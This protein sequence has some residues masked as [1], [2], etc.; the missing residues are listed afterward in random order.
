MKKLTVLQCSNNLSIGG[1]ERAM[2]EFSVNLDKKKYN[3]MVGAKNTE[4][5]RKKILEKNNIPIIQLDEENN[6]DIVKKYNIDIVHSHGFNLRTFPDSVKK[7]NEVIFDEMLDLNA[8]SNWVISKSL[9]YKFRNIKE[10]K[11]GKNIQVVY[12]PQN[13]KEWEK[14]KLSKSSITKIRKKLNMDDKI[15]LG[16]LGRAQPSKTDFLLIK[17]APQIAKQI[18]N[19]FFIFVGLPYLYQKKLLKHKILKDKVLFLPETSKDK[20]IAIFY[21]IIDIFWHTASRGETFGNVNTEAMIFKKPV[22]TH[23]TPINSN[24]HYTTDVAQA[25][26]VE[27]NKTGFVA[28]SPEDVVEAVKRFSKNKKLIKKMGDKGHYKVKEKYSSKIVVKEFDKIANKWFF[29]KRETPKPSSEEV[30]L[31]CENFDSLEKNQIKISTLKSQK[32]YLKQKKRFYFEE[33]LYLVI[34][35]ILRKTFNFDLEKINKQKKS[36]KSL[37]I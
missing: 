23:Y 20:E 34:R 17:S 7:I 2:Q 5:P 11:Y 13:I 24:K 35:Y 15:V 33:Y 9:Y 4:G 25:E 14:H 6:E 16:R 21:Q 27:N 22:I 37:E 28:S 32:K 18:P 8:D 12:Y 31:F 36:F 26:I 1:I 10:L 19:S 3:V 29:G 30:D